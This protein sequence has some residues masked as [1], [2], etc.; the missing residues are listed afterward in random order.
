MK[1]SLAVSCSGKTCDLRQ[2]GAIC[3]YGGGSTRLAKYL[4]DNLRQHQ[5]QKHASQNNVDRECNC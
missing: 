3:C 1:L 5:K 2:A 4:P